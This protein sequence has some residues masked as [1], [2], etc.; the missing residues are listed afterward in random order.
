MSVSELSKHPA[1]MIQC[2][3]RRI[4]N[5]KDISPM[6]HS[7]EFIG[8]PYMPS[9]SLHALLSGVSAQAFT[10]S[11]RSVLVAKHVFEVGDKVCD[12]LERL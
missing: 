1:R 5:N 8:E 3:I 11:W 10:A 2:E 12:Q 7:H 4:G 9:F 6:I